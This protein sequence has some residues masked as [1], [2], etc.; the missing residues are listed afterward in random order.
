M[1]SE[2]RARAGN[3]AEH[4]VGGA[5]NVSMLIGAMWNTTPSP[6]RMMRSAKRDGGRAVPPQASFNMLL[7]ARGR[8]RSRGASCRRTGRHGRMRAAQRAARD[9]QT[10]HRPLAGDAALAHRARGELGAAWRSLRKSW[11]R[12]ATGDRRGRSELRSGCWAC[13]PQATR[14][15]RCYARRWTRWASRPRASSTPVPSS[16][17][18][19][20]SAVRT[21][22][23]R[24]ASR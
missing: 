9:S 5:V 22:G 10:A 24:H 8:L 13:S 4:L 23:S 1:E 21:G 19:P 12:P 14:R 17:S 20:R 2:A 6:R 18:A 16:I 3:R 11:P 15:S 7:S